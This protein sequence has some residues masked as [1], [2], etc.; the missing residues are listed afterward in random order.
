M[1]ALGLLHRPNRRCHG[2]GARCGGG[3]RVIHREFSATWARW[4]SSWGSLRGA[5][6]GPV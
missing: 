4:S 6:A 1:P 3:G 5:S 2:A